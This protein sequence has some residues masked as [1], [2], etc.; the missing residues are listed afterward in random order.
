[1]TSDWRETTWGDEVSLEYGKGIR[2]YQD[3]DGPVPVFGTNGQVGWTDEPLTTGPG[4]ILGR[5]GAYRGIHYSK[6]PFF[7]IDTAYYVQPKSDLDMRWLYYSMIHHRLGSIDDGSPI[8]STTR[9]AVYVRRF[10][11]PDEDTQTA[12]A[13]IL[14]DLDD[15][16]DLL[17]EMNRTL[18]EIARAL[19]R[20][21]FVDFEPVRAKIAGATS[22]RGM[23]QSLFDALPVTFEPSK[24]GN[25]PSGWSVGSVD[26]VIQLMRSGV[27]P[28]EHP[29][30]VYQHFSLPAFDRDQEP[31]LAA[32][33]SI[34]S[35]KYAVPED[36]ILFSKLNP[37]IPRI[38][39]SRDAKKDFP[40]IASTEFLVCVPRNGWS[41]SYAYCLMS[42]AKFIERLTKH[43]TGTS[44]SH[45]RIKPSQFEEVAI[46][47][48]PEEYRQAFDNLGR[49]ILGRIVRNHEERGILVSLREAL[50]PKLISGEV[51]VPDLESLGLTRISDGG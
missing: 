41:R 27:K 46:P 49:H 5:K 9:A 1:M 48:P 38:W 7:V 28:F 29:E 16:L 21:W 33:S 24:I 42:Q 14:G 31:D 13:K 2:G 36:S 30:Q 26:D 40:Q 19:F 23:P 51:E 4:I 6:D 45:Q 22:F 39:L 43:A 37:R 18:E 12:T 15:K 3:A 8:P 50:L 44:N 47:I 17:L 25:V 34:K 10:K 11:V 20:A 32:G 35:G